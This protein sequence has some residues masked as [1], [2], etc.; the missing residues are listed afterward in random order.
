MR[1]DVVEA[2]RNRIRHTVLPPL[3][4]ACAVLLSAT[5][6]IYHVISRPLVKLAQSAEQAMSSGNGDGTAI[7]TRG[8]VRN[9]ISTLTEAFGRMAAKAHEGEVE[10]SST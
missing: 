10:V 4:I 7:E 6:L 5:L 3:A 9:V 2:L 8:R 1:D